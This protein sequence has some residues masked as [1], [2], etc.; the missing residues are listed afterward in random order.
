MRFL[1]NFAS[2]GVT[3]PHPSVK[4]NPLGFKN[5]GLQPQKAPKSVFLVTICPKGVCPLNGFLPNLAWG[6]S[7]RIAPSCKIFPLWL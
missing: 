6:G 1:Q 4:F 2:G 7:P 3:S 5:V